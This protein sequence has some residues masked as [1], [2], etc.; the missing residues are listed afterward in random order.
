MVTTHLEMSQTLSGRVSVWCSGFTVF[1]VEQA[2]YSVGF[3]D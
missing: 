3:R 2:P 1:S